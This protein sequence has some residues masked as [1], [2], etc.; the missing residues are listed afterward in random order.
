VQVVVPGA[1]YALME[2]GN[3]Y[4][5]LFT[6][7]GA[8]LLAGVGLLEPSEFAFVTLGIAVIGDLGAV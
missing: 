1:S 8:F 6:I 7:L 3:A 2:F 5:G 4:A